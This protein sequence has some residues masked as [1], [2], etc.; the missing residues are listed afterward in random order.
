MQKPEFGS[1]RHIPNFTPTPFGRKCWLVSQKQIESVSTTLSV[2]FC[3]KLPLVPVR[4]VEGSIAQWPAV[5][6]R[7]NSRG[8]LHSPATCTRLRGRAM[9]ALNSGKTYRMALKFLVLQYF[10]RKSENNGLL[11]KETESMLKNNECLR[12]QNLE[13]KN[14]RLINS[15]LINSLL[16]L[17][18]H[19]KSVQFI[20]VFRSTAYHVLIRQ[21]SEVHENSL[22]RC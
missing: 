1:W 18:Y 13:W 7:E 9:K 3:H 4:P 14:Y 15:L 19:S 5:L 2:C 6:L 21:S 10:P 22:Q 17:K 11:V 20:T 8:H 16:W 12:K